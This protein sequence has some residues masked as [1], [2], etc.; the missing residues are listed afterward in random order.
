MQKEIGSN[1]HGTPCT[2]ALQGLVK[3]CDTERQRLLSEAAGLD[4][5]KEVLSTFGTPKEFNRTVDAQMH[6]GTLVSF[7]T[8]MDLLM[9][10]FMLLRGEDRRHCELA[11][12]FTVDDVNE[13]EN[14]NARMLVLRIGQGKVCSRLRSL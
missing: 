13:A 9:S 4:R 5:G 2:P 10:K 14:G 7:R 8:R 6:L 12:L 11:D 3:Y 1:Q